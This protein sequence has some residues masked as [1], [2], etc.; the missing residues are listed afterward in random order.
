MKRHNLFLRVC[1]SAFLVA[2]CLICLS[3]EVDAATVY[4]SG[5][6]QY[7]IYNNEATVVGLSVSNFSG[8]LTIP[9]T[10]GGAPVRYIGYGAFEDCTGLTAVSIPDSVVTIESDAF[11][12]CTGLSQISIPD[13][14]TSIYGYAFY[15]CN[16]LA[17]V[18]ITDPSAWC[19]IQFGSYYSN[20][21]EYAKNLH[22]VDDTGRAVPNVSLDSTVTMIP[23]YAFKGC[24]TLVSIE[25]PDSVTTFGQYAFDGC[26]NLEYNLYGNGK[27]LGNADNPYLFLVSAESKSI[28]S[29]QIHDDCIAIANYAFFDCISLDSVTIGD[30]VTIIGKHAFTTCY[31]LTSVDIPD[32]VVTIDEYAFSHCTNLSSATMGSG[33]TNI[34]LSAFYNSG[35]LSVT[36]PD[37]VKVISG[38]AFSNCK[39]LSSVVIPSSV[40]TIGSSAFENSGLTTVDLPD[41]VNAIQ[42][43]AF[44][45]CNRL[46]SV[47]IP[48]NVTT[49]V[50]Y[51]FANCNSLTNVIIQGNLTAIKHGAFEN[52]KSL[53]TVTIPK[54]VTQF[55]KNAFY[56]CSNLKDFWYG[57]DQTQR[58]NIDIDATNNS[59]LS[60]VSWHYN[61]CLHR[62]HVYS[63]MSG[64]CTKCEWVNCDYGKH[65]FNNECDTDCNICMFTRTIA[66]V[67]DNERD[68]SCSEC[69]IT[70]SVDK[71]EIVTL[72]TTQN[73]GMGEA[74]KYLGL[75]FRVDYSDGSEA[76]LNADRA[77]QITIDTSSAGK[78]TAT[79]SFMEHSVPFDMYVHTDADGGSVVHQ[80]S[81]YNLYASYDNYPNYVSTSE[82]RRSF[83][84]PGA[85]SLEIVF[86]GGSKVND[87][88]YLLL[89]YGSTNHYATDLSGKTITIPGDSFTIEIAQKYTANYRLTGQY[90]IISVRATVDIYHPPVTDLPTFSC[91]QDGLSEGSHCDICGMVIKAQSPVKAPGHKY[92]N[93]CDTDCNTCGETREFTGHYYSSDCDATCNSCGY[94]RSVPDHVFTNPCD[95][96]CDVCGYYIRATSHVYDPWRVTLAPTCTTT[97]IQRRDC[98]HCDYYQTDS[99]AETGH[100]YESVFTEPTCINDGYTTYTCHCKDTYIDGYV[101][102]QGHSFTNYISDGNATCTQDGSVTAICDRCDETDTQPDSDSKLGH[103]FTDYRS[104]GDAT[105]LKDGTET[106][107]CDRCELINTRTDAGTKLGHSFTDYRSNMDATCLVDGTETA[108]CDRCD[109]TDRRIDSDSALGHNYVGNITPPT[110]TDMG[111]TTYTCSHCRDLY[112]AEEKPKLGHS[113][114]EYKG[115]G[116]ATCLDD[117]TETAKCDRCD[118]T[119]IRIAADSALGHDHKPTVTAPT[120]TE[121]GFTVYA[122][123]RCDD[124]YVAD[125]K[126]ELG[127]SF[128]HYVSNNDATYD[129]DGTKTAKCDRCDATDTVIDEGS[130]LI[131]NGWFADG[132]KWYYYIDDVMKTGWLQLGSTWYYMDSQGL[133][134][135]SWKQI[136][137]IWYY[138]KSSGAMVTGWLQSGGTWYCFNASGAMVTG[139]L[140]SGSTWY[141]F[142]SSGAMVTGT[143]TIGGK[144]N[145]F[146]ASGAWLG[147]VSQNGWVQEGGK[148][149]YYQNGA[150][151]TGWKQISGKWYYFNTSGV[152]QTGW[153]QVGG[154]WYYFQSGGAMQTGW[155]KLG[156]TWYYFHSS[157]AMATSPVTLGGKTYRFDANGACLNP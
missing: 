152:M 136:G 147:E 19:K 40:T 144:V 135:T 99:L 21:M 14:V 66:H 116:D 142:N 64:Q 36:I 156:N 31:A 149:Y 50:T 17:D 120:C 111:Y 124:A 60:G 94:F 96:Y 11:F 46:K 103:S 32:S 74:P 33:V 26:I 38:N 112:V 7:T 132:S 81:T 75:T 87:Y 145:K 55:S 27:Y 16:K 77:D 67:Y 90:Q 44:S 35:L 51:T 80:G 98:I 89:C 61:T 78:K 101:P 134:Q 85:K 123:T 146:D 69:G 23:D 137:G 4:T 48:R 22:I 8:S 13:S 140:Q 62:Y 154:T 130:K 73:C 65:V 125:E 5:G 104:N 57:G 54:S 3:V 30:S 91:M 122:C 76:T 100:C 39:K 59:A 102:A 127:H 1:L 20:P 24:T 131:R 115:N 129:A 150:K 45:G 113:F 68:L 157:G 6:I 133:M 49:I 42:S 15:G 114:T 18:Y 128:T 153:L 92:N 37:K 72:P 52:C 34:G 117:G 56:G 83:R 93:L 138:F 29:A 107:K 88:G 43:R 109:Q 53:T 71:L 110:C 108:K 82:T 118:V 151:A 12:G 97:G 155:L 126:P 2:F 148:W 119:D 84:Y 58:E 63:E 70:R 25:I 86:Q 95:S 41:S 47:S 106:A 105:C 143:V 139:W 9:S 10:L 141:Y 28:T 121:I 79:L